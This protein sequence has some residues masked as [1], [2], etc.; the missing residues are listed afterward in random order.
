MPNQQIK[1]LSKQRAQLLLQ[2]RS[3]EELATVF[4]VIKH[5]NNTNVIGDE[6]KLISSEYEPYQQELSETLIADKV[7]KLQDQ[8]VTISKEIHTLKEAQAA[9][10]G[11]KPS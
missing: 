6:V 3:Y 1:E 11:A 7:L 4:N 5:Y 8:I 9:P 10:A 2:I